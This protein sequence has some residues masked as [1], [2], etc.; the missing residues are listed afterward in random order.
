[1]LVAFTVDGQEQESDFKNEKL[2]LYNTKYL[3]EF[4]E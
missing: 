1:M 3:Q 4:R 2:Y